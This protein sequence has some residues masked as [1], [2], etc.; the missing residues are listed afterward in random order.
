MLPLKVS[1]SAALPWA[2]PTSNQCCR[3]AE[4]PCVQVSRSTWPCVSDWMRSSPTAAAAFKAS[5]T[6]A[7][8]R[9][10][11]SPVFVALCAQTPA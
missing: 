9:F 11:I 2:S 10:S 3:W 5:E 6:S 8:V 4:E 7:R 1:Q